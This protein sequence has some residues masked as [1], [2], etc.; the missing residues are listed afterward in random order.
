MPTTAL[1]RLLIDFGPVL[2]LFIAGRVVEFFT[3][4]TYFL[5]ATG[6]AM[7]LS[8]FVERRLPL[9]PI[10]LGAFIILFGTATVLL[11]QSDIIIFADTI[12]YS[13]G[14]LALGFSLWRNE[15]IL[16]RLFGGTFAISDTGWRILTKR[17]LIVF[18]LG[19]VLNEAVRLGLSPEAWIDF[20]FYKVIF[21]TLFGLYQFRLAR[22]YRL[23]E[24]ANSWGLR[25]RD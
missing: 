10:G 6:V 17:W 1:F 7:L 19:G 9:I 23:P 20:K 21:I 5:V 2:V 13:V 24:V 4:I 16:K 8:W 15:L 18:I 14:A 12:Y 22:Q 11:Q 3:A 25:M